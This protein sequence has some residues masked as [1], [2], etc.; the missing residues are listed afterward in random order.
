MVWLSV[1]PLP[2]MSSPFTVL[3]FG[4]ALCSTSAS[5]IHSAPRLTGDHR[6]LHVPPLRQV[7]RVWWWLLFK[8]IGLMVLSYKMDRHSHWR[9]SSNDHI[10][11]FVLARS[12]EPLCFV[13][14][15]HHAFHPTVVWPVLTQVHAFLLRH[16][17]ADPD[18]QCFGIFGGIE[19][20]SISVAL[21]FAAQ[22]ALQCASILVDWFLNAT[23][24]LFVFFCS[25]KCNLISFALYFL[26][27]VDCVYFNQTINFVH[28]Y[29]SIKCTYQSHDYH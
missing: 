20:Q 3:R 25:I 29:Q 19:R 9:L 2:R 22:S 16:C 4:S 10:G 26:Y 18:R 7:S 15:S 24:K 5:A 13:S 12:N 6:R 28:L 14:S 8:A 17:N 23:K 11:R 1:F 21:F 27:S